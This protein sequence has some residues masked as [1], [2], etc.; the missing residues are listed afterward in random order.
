MQYAVIQAGGH[1]YRVKEGDTLPIDKLD[2]QVGDKVRFDRV[3]LVQD[4][5]GIQVGKPFLAKALVEATIKEQK[6]DKKV[7]VFKYK[8]R[9]NYKKM[10]GHKQ[11]LTVVEI[12]KI[13]HNA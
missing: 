1:Q 6:R 5:Q 4:D 3:L 7:L 11:P 2:G 13:S 8:R 10:R 9:K 12:G